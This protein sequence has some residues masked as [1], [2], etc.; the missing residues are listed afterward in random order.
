MP[1]AK[2]PKRPLPPIPWWAWVFAAACVLSPF[3]TRVDAITGAVAG[4][5]AAGCVAAARNRNL[6]VGVRI[7]I[8]TLITAAAWGIVI[9]V[10]GTIAL[11]N[12]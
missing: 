7:L 6:P 9:A 2:K 4:G 3:L 10:V 12:R 5:S 1:D 8:C 11:L